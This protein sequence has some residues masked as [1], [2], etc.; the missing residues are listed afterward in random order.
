MRPL[1]LGVAL[2]LIAMFGDRLRQISWRSVKPVFALLYLTQMLW[3][4][5]LAYQACWGEFGFH[6]LT[7][8]AAMVVLIRCTRPNWS[9]GVPFAFLRANAHLTQPDL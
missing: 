1:A 3:A 8:A 2:Y 6:E 7:G 4:L 9:H 5:S